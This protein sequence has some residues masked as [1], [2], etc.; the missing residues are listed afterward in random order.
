MLFKHE[1]GISLSKVSKDDL[2]LLL[3]LKQ[4]SWFGTHRISLVNLEDQ[5]FWFE[6]LDKNIHNPNALFLI[7]EKDNEKIGDFKFTS[8][9][10]VSRKA[11]V[12]WDIFAN[13]RGKGLGKDLVKAGITF[14]A[15]LLNL[16]R[17]NAEILKTNIASQ[18]CAEYAGFTLEGTRKQE[19]WKNNEYVD[20]LLYGYLSSM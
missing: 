10:W 17:M 8:I 2:P 18:K 9:D 14:G 11:D 3:E 16:H 7:A 5:L 13:R 6:K 12:G 1:N 15:K 19:I 4:E 20:N